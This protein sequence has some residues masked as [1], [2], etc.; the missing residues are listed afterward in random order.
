MAFF[1]PSGQLCARRANPTVLRRLP[2]TGTLPAHSREPMRKGGVRDESFFSTH[3]FLRRSARI[4][5][6][7][8]D[9]EQSAARFRRTGCRPDG[10]RDGSIQRGQDG[11]SRGGDPGGRHR[12][13]LQRRVLRDLPLRSGRGRRQRRARN[14]VRHPS[15]ERAVRPALSVRGFLDA[16]SGNRPERRVRLPGGDRAA[17]GDD[18]GRP[19]DDAALRTRARGCDARPDVQADRVQ[20]AFRPRRDRRPR[21]R[22]DRPV[23]RPQGGR[24][25]RMEGA[26]SD[27]LPVRGRRLRQRDGN[28]ESGVSR[29]ELPAGGLRVALMQSRPGRST[30]TA[31]ESGRSRTS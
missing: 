7:C 24:K 1:Y 10:G 21:E 22:G 25:V 12:A 20:R 3:R 29:R 23:D 19:P 8:S 18:R 31:R 26:E 15:L 30:T 9:F 14:A 4:S 2:T 13:R 6:A 17:G 27:A 11:V 5:G 28:H 16:V